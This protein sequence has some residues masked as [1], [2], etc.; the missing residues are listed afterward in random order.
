MGDTPEQLRR[1]VR[2]FPLFK[3]MLL[4]YCP[5]RELSAR[6]HLFGYFFV[7]EGD[8]DLCFVLVLLLELLLELLLLLLLLLLL[9]VFTMEF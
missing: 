5:E 6:A 1:V 7:H 3:S 2:Y 9:H 4:L 8:V